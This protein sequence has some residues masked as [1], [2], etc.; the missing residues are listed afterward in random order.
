M[1]V[2]CGYLGMLA[3][4]A[5]IGFLSGA[6][7]LNGALVVAVVA[8]AFAAAAAGVVAPITASHLRRDTLER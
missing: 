2:G 1:V 4:P 5:V 7:G 6:V 8:L 3:G